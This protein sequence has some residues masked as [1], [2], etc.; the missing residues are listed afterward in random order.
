MSRTGILILVGILTIITP[1]SGL[2]VAMRSLLAVVFGAIVVS[3]GV[4]LRAREV[5]VADATKEAPSAVLSE[6]PHQA[7]G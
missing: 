7:I 1:Y 6:E 5:K 4:S 3:V 2:P